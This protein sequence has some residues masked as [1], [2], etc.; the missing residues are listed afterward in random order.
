[1]DVAD[2]CHGVIRGKKLII[3]WWSAKFSVDVSN[4]KSLSAEDEGNEGVI[5]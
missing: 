4:L 3:N 2:I 5:L 1:M